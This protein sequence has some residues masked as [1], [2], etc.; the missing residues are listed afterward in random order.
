MALLESKIIQIA[1]DPAVI[2]NATE[3]WGSFGWTVLSVQVTHSQDSRTYQQW[4]E[5]GTNYSTTETT[6]INYA[7]ITFQRD[8]KMNH[9][10]E[11]VTLERQYHTLINEMESKIH[12]V[13]QLD[14]P[15][16]NSPQ[17]QKMLKDRGL[18]IF[19][20]YI[21]NYKDSFRGA[22]KMLGISVES[23]W[24]QETIM[25]IRV[26]YVDQLD[27]IREQAEALL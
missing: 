11:I 6:T 15:F 24:A 25:E 5:Y 22:A 19:Q 16:S 8:K 21:E 13:T 2:N 14:N 18:N 20:R 4:Y 1:N 12:E 27:S 10:A 3:I 9:Y 7:T 23:K 26:E 17:K